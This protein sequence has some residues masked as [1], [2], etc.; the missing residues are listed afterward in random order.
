MG[1]KFWIDRLEKLWGFSPSQEGGGKQKN[2]Q[3]IQRPTAFAM[4]RPIWRRESRVYDS[5]LGIPSGFVN[6]CVPSIYTVEEVAV[7]DVDF[8]RRDSNDG[9]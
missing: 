8:V 2:Q 6:L 5:K 4:K 1:S 9:S 3:W 7:A